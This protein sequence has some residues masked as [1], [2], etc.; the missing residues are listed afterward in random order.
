MGKSNAAWRKYYTDER[1]AFGKAGFEREFE[2]FPEGDT[3]LVEIIG[4]GGVISFPHTALEFSAALHARVVSS[5]YNSDVKEVIALGVFHGHY[6]QGQCLFRDDICEEIK[7]GV[8]KRANRLLAHE[9]S[10][11]NFL[12]AVEWYAEINGVT[13]LKVFPLYISYPEM[14]KRE[15]DPEYK[16]SEK[17]AKELKQVMGEKTAVVCTGD[18]AHYGS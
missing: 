12:A 11:D 5:L 10:L 2:G 8:V 4:K 3:D 18:W 13:A 1:E 6:D 9:F 14:G 15:S 16:M 17:I 7:C